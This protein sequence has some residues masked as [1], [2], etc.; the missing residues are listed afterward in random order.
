MRLRPPETVD[1]QRVFQELVALIESLPLHR[2]VSE[3]LGPELGMRVTAWW[4]VAP[5][6]AW[7]HLPAPLREQL[8]PLIDIAAL[9]PPIASEVELLRSQVDF[10]LDALPPEVAA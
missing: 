2:L 8:S 3:R 10:L 6:A 1:Q 7:R 9:P 5:A 4:L